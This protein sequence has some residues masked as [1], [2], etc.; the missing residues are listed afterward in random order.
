[1]PSETAAQKKER[2]QREE[3]AKQKEQETR[4]LYSEYGLDYDNEEHRTSVAVR[5]LARRLELEEERKKEKPP[6]KGKV[7]KIW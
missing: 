1:M 4:D 6:S 5:R 7:L 2:E 3:E